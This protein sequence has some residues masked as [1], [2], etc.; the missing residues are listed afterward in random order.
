VSRVHGGSYDQ[1]PAVEA[2]LEKTRADIAAA[3]RTQRAALGWTQEQVAEKVGCAVTYFQKLEAAKCT[4]SLRFLSHLSLVLS[5][6]LIDLVKPAPT[7]R[8]RRTS[9]KAA[10]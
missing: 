5:C 6:D 1:D 9:R 4:P 2:R 8:R 10:N 3:V 7:L